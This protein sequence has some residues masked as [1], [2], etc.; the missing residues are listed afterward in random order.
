MSTKAP[1]EGKYKIKTDVDT[2]LLGA[3]HRMQLGL[4][5][6]PHV[7]QHDDVDHPVHDGYD[8]R[9]HL[10]DEKGGRTAGHEGRELTKGPGY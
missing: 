1:H 10:S 8:R 4:A 3:H 9:T 6:D 7:P 5:P 2:K